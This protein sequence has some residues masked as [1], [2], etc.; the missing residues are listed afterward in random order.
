M[1]VETSQSSQKCPE[2][3]DCFLSQT[4]KFLIN[5]FTRRCT[6]TNFQGGGTRNPQEGNN[7]VC[8]RVGNCEAK[9]GQGSLPRRK[10]CCSQIK[11]EMSR[12]SGLLPVPAQ[13]TKFLINPFTRRCTLTHVQGGGTRNPQE[14]NNAVCLRVGN[15]GKNGQGSLPRRRTNTK[16]ILNCSESTEKNTELILNKF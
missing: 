12:I 7:A 8:L 1:R 6:L 3:L 13:T 15:C 2:F 9:N 10:P 11:P 4:T 16:P 5:P 14:S